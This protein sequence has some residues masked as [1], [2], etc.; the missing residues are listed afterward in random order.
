MRRLTTGVLIAGLLAVAAA[1][2][3]AAK[4]A[5]T[6]EVVMTV[7]GCDFTFQA[8]WTRAKVEQT[9]A[10]FRLP[11]SYQGL[12][13]GADRHGNAGSQFKNYGNNQVIRVHQFESTV[14]LTFKFAVYFWDEAGNVLHI[15]E[16]EELTL[17]CE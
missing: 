2:P 16:S 4:P 3:V 14:E 13:I 5:A 15:W 6:Y 12:T 1:G 17:F 9:A 7:D 8:S 10:T 11:V